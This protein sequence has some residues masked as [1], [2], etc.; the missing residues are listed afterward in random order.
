MVMKLSEK[1]HVGDISD[2]RPRVR[3]EKLT[4]EMQDKIHFARTVL[5]MSDV[6]I[7]QAA[8]M[9]WT[10]RGYVPRDER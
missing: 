1:K 5:L 6:A 4:E 10:P 8:L 9:G 3:A 2:F 7:V